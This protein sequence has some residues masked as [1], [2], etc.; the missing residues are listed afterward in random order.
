MSAARIVSDPAVTTGRPVVDGTRLTVE[1][2]LDELDGGMTVG[3]VPVLQPR[4]TRTAVFAALA[5]AAV[6]A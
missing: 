4:L 3:E 1:Y 2:I 6:G 5:F